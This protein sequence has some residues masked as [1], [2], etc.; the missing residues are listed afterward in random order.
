[1]RIV[2]NKLPFFIGVA[3]YLCLVIHELGTGRKLT[4]SK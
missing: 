3:N 2:I 1:M 4:V